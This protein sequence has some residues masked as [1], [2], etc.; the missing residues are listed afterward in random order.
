MSESLKRILTS[1][2]EFY[3]GIKRCREAST[4]SAG[5]MK[6]AYNRLNRLRERY[7]YEKA[8]LEASERQALEKVFEDDNL[9]AGLMD[10]RQIGEHVQKRTGAEVPLMVPIVTNQRITMPVETSAGAFFA[11]LVVTLYDKKG[12]R[13]ITD[14]LRNLQ[15]AEERIRKALMRPES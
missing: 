1:A 6:D 4:Y 8:N 10:V 11:G 15:V 9:I 3:E 13:R 2:D 5:D 7:C 14:H 12:E